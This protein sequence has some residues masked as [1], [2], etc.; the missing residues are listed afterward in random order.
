MQLRS[1]LKIIHDKCN[2][3]GKDADLIN[4][5]KGANIFGFIKAA[6]AV[7]TCSVI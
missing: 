4:Y 6:D 1:I 2:G 7:L 3:H 5:S